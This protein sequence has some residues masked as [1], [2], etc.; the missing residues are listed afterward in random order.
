VATW[1][2]IIERLYCLYISDSA[3]IHALVG[4]C[5]SFHLLFIVPFSFFHTR[6]LKKNR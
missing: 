4:Q 1:V 2:V 6:V 3:D 5:I